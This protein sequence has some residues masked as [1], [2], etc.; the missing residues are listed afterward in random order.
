MS[1]SEVAWAVD[2][3]VDE[4]LGDDASQGVVR[5]VMSELLDRVDAATARVI[6]EPLSFP[7]V[8]AKRS[9]RSRARRRVAESAALRRAVSGALDL[10]A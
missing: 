2:L 10:V 1:A 9:A 7:S 4:H 5:T 3:M 8:N 6:S